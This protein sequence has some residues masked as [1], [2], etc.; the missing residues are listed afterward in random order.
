MKRKYPNKKEKKETVNKI[1]LV[2]API[3]RHIDQEIVRRVAATYKWVEYSHNS[4]ANQ[5]R[6]RIQLEYKGILKDNYKNTNE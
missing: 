3:G 1:L 6:K 5:R 4:I 2:I